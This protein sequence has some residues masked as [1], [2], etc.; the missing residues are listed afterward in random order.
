MT[1]ARISPSRFSELTESNFNTNNTSTVSASLD[2]KDNKWVAWGAKQ[3]SGG[4]S[5]HIITLQQSLDNST[6]VNTASTLTGTGI[7]NNIQITTRYV[8]LAVTTAEGS[9]SIVSIVIHGK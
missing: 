9:A 8:R 1:G 5:T 7:V 3:T 6:W 2:I 4:H